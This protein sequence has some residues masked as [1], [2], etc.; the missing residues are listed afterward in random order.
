MAIFSMLACRRGWSP[1]ADSHSR[2]LI[3][4]QTRSALESAPRC[5]A[6]AFDS[7]VDDDIRRPSQRQSAK[8][9]HPLRWTNAS[10]PNALAC[11]PKHRE[12]DR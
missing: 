11:F 7:P 2:P 10:V 12:F 3:A 5:I 8:S 4:A 9:G 1:A 6:P